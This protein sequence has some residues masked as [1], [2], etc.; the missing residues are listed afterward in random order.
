MPQWTDAAGNVLPVETA[1]LYFGILLI[2]F[3][4][5]SISRPKDDRVADWGIGASVIL[6]GAMCITF[7]LWMQALLPV[8]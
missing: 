6:G 4:G 7:P 5:Y 1:L 3:G 2:L 8:A